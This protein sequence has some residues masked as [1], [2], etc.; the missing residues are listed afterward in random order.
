MPVSVSLGLAV[1]Q[2]MPPYATVLET[3]TT[4]ADM[5]EA[6]TF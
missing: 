4:Y 6:Y 1:C 2:R 3:Y 5:H